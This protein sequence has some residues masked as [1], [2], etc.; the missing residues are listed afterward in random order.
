MRRMWIKLVQG[1]N[2]QLIKASAN[3]LVLLLPNLCVII[4]I[5]MFEGFIFYVNVVLL[6]FCKDGTFNANYII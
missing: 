2:T 3:K 1:Q 6:R 5:V 4:I